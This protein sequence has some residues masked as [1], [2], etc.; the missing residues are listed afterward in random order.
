MSFLVDGRGQSNC[1]ENCGADLSVTRIAACCDA[2]SVP[3]APGDPGPCPFCD[4]VPEVASG[5]AYYQHP[6]DESCFM[7]GQ[8]IRLNQLPAWNRRSESSSAAA[9]RRFVSKVGAALTEYREAAG[10]ETPVMP[11]EPND[12]HLV[13][14]CLS[15]NHGYGLMDPEERDQ[16]HR[17]CREWWRSISR[18]MMREQGE[19]S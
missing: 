13:S 9:A 3:H 10:I 5:G 17:D 18:A 15:F 19:N 7:S 8:I 4:A 6:H 14:A 12:D 1:C 2:P 16:L 11:D